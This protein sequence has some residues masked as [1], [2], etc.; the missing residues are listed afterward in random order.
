MIVALTGG[1]GSGKTTVAKM[2]KKLEVP[3]YDSDSEAKKLMRSSKKIR[4]AIKAL[5]G[6]GAYKGKK[7]NKTLIS[8]RIFKDKSLL[9]QLNAIVHPAVRK[10][11]KAWVKRQNTPYVIQE[12][13]VIFENGMHGFYDK[14]VLVTAPEELRLARVIERDAISESE[15]AS[16]MGNQWED[17]RKIELS[18]YIIENLELKDTRTKVQEIHKRLLDH[19]RG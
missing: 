2:F 6:D 11:F 14:I 5:L 15:V 12:A 19:S 7:L 10:H 1:I 9:K 4:T 8:D 16:R 3:V 13:A 18:D 17:A